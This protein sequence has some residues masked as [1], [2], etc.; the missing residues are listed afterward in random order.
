MGNLIKSLSIFI[1]IFN[2][3]YSILIS[4][5]ADFSPSSSSLHPDRKNIFHLS[6]CKQNLFGLF[7]KN[8]NLVVKLV[9]DLK[10]SSKKPIHGQAYFALLEMAFNRSFSSNSRAF[11]HIISHLTTSDII[12]PFHSFW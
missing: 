9:N 6:H 1:L 11:R 8:E 4:T 2:Y 5:S 3:G 12:F 7:C 10:P